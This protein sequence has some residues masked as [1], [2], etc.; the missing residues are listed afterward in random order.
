MSG[1]LPTVDHEVLVSILV[2]G[3]VVGIALYLAIVG[4]RRAALLYVLVAIPVS[5]FLA[6]MVHLGWY[7]GSIESQGLLT[8]WQFWKGGYSVL[9]FCV[10][11]AVVWYVAA[12]G[13]RTPM[14]GQLT[15]G[16]YVVMPLS[17]AIGRV[18]CLFAGCCYGVPGGGDLGV[19]YPAMTEPGLKFGPIP[20]HPVQVYEATAN[21]FLLGILW[22]L[23]HR[24]G[25]PR[26]VCGTY[27]VGYGTIR[28]FMTTLRG[29]QWVV[30][31]PSMASLLLVAIGVVLLV[32]LRVWKPPGAVS[33]PRTAG[34]AS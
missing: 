15:A 3:V 33:V 22:W 31:A 1:E 29:D 21:L 25:D 6:R 9:G 16:L 4:E 8:F 2:G 32:S 19:I 18:V 10:G 13:G 28:Y 7:I 11:P 23:W 20:I 30:N 14:V 27:F 34:A 17:Q 5:L 26:S 24:G 12:V